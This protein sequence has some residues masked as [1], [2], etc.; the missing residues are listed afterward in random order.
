[1]GGDNISKVKITNEKFL[2]KNMKMKHFKTVKWLKIYMYIFIYIDRF[3]SKY[4]LF[5]YKGAHVCVS[6]YTFLSVCKQC[7][8]CV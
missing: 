7:V 4:D 2:T 1:M 5:E 8:F 3:D 6:M